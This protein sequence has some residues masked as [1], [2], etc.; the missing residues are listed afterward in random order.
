VAQHW[1]RVLYT[2]TLRSTVWHAFQQH[3]RG[4][5]PLPVCPNHRPALSRVRDPKPIHSVLGTTG[6]LAA[7]CVCVCVLSWRTT[8][9]VR[10]NTH[11][12]RGY[13]VRVGT[14]LWYRALSARVCRAIRAG[15]ACHTPGSS[16]SDTRYSPDIR[17][18]CELRGLCRHSYFGPRTC[19]GGVTNVIE[20]RGFS[21]RVSPSHP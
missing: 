5:K 10:G 18:P 3:T 14:P 17:N 13:H 4:T 12:A 2:P 1:R 15:T 7:W 19:G 9:L 8:P 11:G 16:L 21:I 6:G 20:V